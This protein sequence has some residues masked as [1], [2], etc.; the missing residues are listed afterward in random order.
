MSIPGP[1]PFH[2]HGWLAPTVGRIHSQQGEYVEQRRRSVPA[3]EIE[4]A[5]SAKIVATFEPPAARL[6]LV[7]ELDLTVDPI[8]MRRFQD[9]A[10][11]KCHDVEVDV[12]DVTYID[13]SLLRLLANQK[14]TIE[15]DGGSFVLTRASLVFALVAQLAGFQQLLPYGLPPDLGS[16]GSDFREPVPVDRTDGQANRLRQ[17]ASG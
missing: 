17:R 12:T 11:L 10:D 7:G 9:I 4:M 14:T 16:R 15:H 2:P 13:A 5:M 6:R 3:S 8:M 1:V